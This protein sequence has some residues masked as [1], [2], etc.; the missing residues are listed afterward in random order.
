[1]ETPG[2]STPPPLAGV[3]QTDGSVL[4]SMEELGSEEFIRREIQAS[5]DIL[6]ELDPSSVSVFVS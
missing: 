2:A 6:P 5:C 4:A 3:T 1:M